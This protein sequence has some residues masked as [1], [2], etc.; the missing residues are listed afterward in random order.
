MTNELVLARHG[1]SVW[2]G[3][4]RYAGSSDV[5]LDA[6]GREQ[7]ERLAAWAADTRID[8]IASSPLRRALDTARPAADAV[9]TDLVVRDELREVDFGVAEGRTIDELDADDPDMVARFRAD[10]VRNHF[11]Q[12]DDPAHAADRVVEALHELVTH[13]DGA[14]LLVVSHNTALRLALCRLL[15]I[16]VGAYRATFPALRPASLTTV[17]LGTASSRAALLDLNVP[18]PAPF[19]TAPPEATRTTRPTRSHT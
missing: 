16:D 2:H 7:A 9:G 14:R 12:A 17:R 4:N 5:Q 11:P 15:G 18:L 10:P 13:H 1:Q 19:S 8:T 6:V 3:E